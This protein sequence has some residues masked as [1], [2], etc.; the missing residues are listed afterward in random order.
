VDGGF[1][2][3]GLADPAVTLCSPPQPT[4][5][6]RGSRAA[7]A[8]SIPT[9]ARLCLRPGF[10]LLPRLHAVFFRVRCHSCCISV[11]GSDHAP[12]HVLHPALG[13]VSEP[14]SPSGLS[15]TQAGQHPSQLSTCMQ[16]SDNLNDKLCSRNCECQY[17]PVAPWYCWISLQ[18][19]AASCKHR[20][21]LSSYSKLD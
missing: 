17:D 11:A 21:P 5:V 9:V 16:V 15:G 13:A 8:T 18:C 14:G 7:R 1:S 2:G 12:W 3:S 20:C 10:L 19:C 4:M 6:S